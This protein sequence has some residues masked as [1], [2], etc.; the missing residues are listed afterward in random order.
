MEFNYK[1]KKNYIPINNDN[2]QI[3]FDCVCGHNVSL[4][5]K[6]YLT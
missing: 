6:L 1:N 5:I 4:N 2:W 3:L